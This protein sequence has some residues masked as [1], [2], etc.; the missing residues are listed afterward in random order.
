LAGKE[1]STAGV[2]A[3]T[4]DGVRLVVSELVGNSVRAC[5]DHVPVVIEVYLGIEV[6]YVNVHDPEPRLPRHGGRPALDDAEA[7]S[8]RGLA[9]VDLLCSG[10]RVARS[11][12]GKQIRCRLVRPSG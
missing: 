3:D 7:E 6:V 2:D 4:I 9:L 8:G 12:I 10:W 5:G 11:P 1:L